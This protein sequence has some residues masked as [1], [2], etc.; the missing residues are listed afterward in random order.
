MVTAHRKG[1]LGLIATISVLV[2]C[3]TVGAGVAIAAPAA[4]GWTIDALAAPTTFLA[5]DN[6]ACLET[7]GDNDVDCAQYEVTATD[8]GSEPTGAGPVTMT[9][10]I[11]GGLTVREIKFG[12]IRSIKTGGEL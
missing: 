4:P 2:V 10:T 3:S 5:G 12:L 6:V 9:A 7:I 11:P 1:S 8:A